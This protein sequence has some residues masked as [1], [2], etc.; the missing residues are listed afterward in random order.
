MRSLPYL[1]IA[2]ALWSCRGSDSAPSCAD[3][4]KHAATIAGR[5]AADAELADGVAACQRDRWPATVRQCLAA[6]RSEPDVAPCLRAVQVAV[7]G[8][9]EGQPESAPLRLEEVELGLQKIARGLDAYA[10]K[11]GSFPVGSAPLTPDRACCVGVDHA[12]PLAPELWAIP[13]W[14]AIGFA[15]RGPHHYQ[16]SY[17]AV[18]PAAK[19]VVR[20]V[21]DRDCDGAAVTYTMTLERSAAGVKVAVD[22]PTSG[23]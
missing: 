2:L 19:V 18:D 7:A 5:S 9:A 12:C 20:A 8:A 23:K 14:T 15:P 17:E 10:A 4:V 16:Y 13:T 3:A 6:A 1:L 11:N 22:R 21:G